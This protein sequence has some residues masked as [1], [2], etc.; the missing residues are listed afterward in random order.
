M[1]VAQLAKRLGVTP[2]AVVQ[3]EKREL[4]GT[5]TLESLRKAA[6][7]LDCELVYALVPKTSLAITLERRVNL[8]AHTLL[9]KAGHLIEHRRSGS[10]FREEVALR[11]RLRTELPRNLWD[12]LDPT[13]A[14]A[15]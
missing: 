7:A 14:G 1:G 8:L 12:D 4:A 9:Q 15:G 3:L 5:V 6:E 2:A 11:Q 10:A 13:E